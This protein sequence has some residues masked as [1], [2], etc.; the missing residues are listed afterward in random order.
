MGLI[1]SYIMGQNDQNESN[2]ALTVWPRCPKL[3]FYHGRYCS[4]LHDLPIGL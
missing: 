3:L 1:A 4:L 2:W